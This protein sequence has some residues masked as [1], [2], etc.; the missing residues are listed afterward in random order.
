MRPLR[1]LTVVTAIIGAC[2]AIGV[3]PAAA[4]PSDPIL[5]YSGNTSLSPGTTYASLGAAA[6]RPI[7]S[8]TVMPGSLSGNACVLLNLNQATFNGTQVTTL[9]AYI[10][11]GG[12]VL[13]IGEN[14][15][16]ANN[17]AFRTLA[18]ALGSS[19]QIQN[20]AY[21]PGFRDTPYIDADPLTRDVLTINYAYTATVS[22][23]APARS[24][25]RRS[26]G[27]DT[28]MAAETLGAGELVALGDANAF[29]SPSGGA[30]LLVANM[31]GTRRTTS[32]AVDC[33]PA[34][35][36]VGATV[37][38]E[39]TVTDTDGGTAVTPTGTVAFTQGGAG[40]GTFDGDGTC[41]LVASGTLG[42]SACSLTYVATIQG[43]QTLTGTYQGTPQSYGSTGSDAHAATLPAPPSSSSTT[44]TGAAGA[45]QTMQVTVPAGGSATLLAGGQPVTTLVVDAEGTY[46]ISPAG[47]ISFTPVAGFAG[48]ARAVSFRVTDV[49]GQSSVAS[50]TPTVD[51]AATSGTPAPTPPPPSATTPARQA[52]VCVSARVMRLHFR[53]AQG[54]ELRSLSITVSEKAQRRLRVG[55]RSTTLDLRGY[56]PASVTVVLRAQTVGGK[57]LISKRTYK[58]CDQQKVA[59]VLKTVVL[60]PA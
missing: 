30:G 53:V 60:Q 5:V 56:A 41:A 26:D 43:A 38:C 25:V 8:T 4:A 28:M 11:G 2:A 17:A 36:L 31:C 48:T 34:S 55:A 42:R 3:A 16:Y 52:V 32:E 44:S 37:T 15:N 1:V 40:A 29:T 9:S 24:L 49:Y 54:T 14:D 21:D 35:A 19:M 23:S 27:S 33:L 58:T 22:F 45:V 59:S 50:F 10:A 57:A 12:R 47:L 13:M 51:A 20:N 39:A 7:S 46:R 6:G 18:T